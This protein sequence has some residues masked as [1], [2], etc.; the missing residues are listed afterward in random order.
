MCSQAHRSHYNVLPSALYSLLHA[1]WFPSFNFPFFSL[2]S[3]FFFPLL[4]LLLPSSLLSSP[5][6][7]ILASPGTIGQ[8]GKRCPSKS[9]ERPWNHL[10]LIPAEILN[11]QYLI[12]S[13]PGNRILDHMCS[14]PSPWYHL[15]ECTRSTSRWKHVLAA[16]IRGIHML[17]SRWMHM[18]LK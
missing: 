13:S 8:P 9:L 12:S 7:Y 6:F 14:L 10:G 3:F 17:C 18:C 5:F 11:D 2:F 16:S 1:L 4:F 15:G